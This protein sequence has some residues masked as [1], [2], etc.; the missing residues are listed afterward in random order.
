RAREAGW[1]A[2]GGG[3]HLR[4]LRHGA[5]V[6]VLT[7]HFTGILHAASI[8]IGMAGTANEQAAG[9]GVP[10]VAAPGR[11]DQFTPGFL[12]RQARLL[13][14]AVVPVDPSGEAIAREV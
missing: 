13:G 9:L 14:G 7:G 1:R 4:L 5:C 2:A 3:A 12:A 6:H 11:G 8:A 10:V